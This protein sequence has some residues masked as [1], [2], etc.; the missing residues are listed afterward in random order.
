MFDEWDDILNKIEKDFGE[1][2][3]NKISDL[4]DENVEEANKQI[5][6]LYQ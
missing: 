5:N 1:E 6:N 2:M 3:A 4:I